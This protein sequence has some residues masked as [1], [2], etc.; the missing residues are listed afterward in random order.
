[1]TND[2][3]LPPTKRKVKARGLM[4]LAETLGSNA[5]VILL[6]A[7]LDHSEGDLVRAWH[8]LDALVTRDPD[9]AEASRWLVRIQKEIKHRK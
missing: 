1:M 2:P 5:E 9:N 3:T 4:D 8:R 6:A 7:W